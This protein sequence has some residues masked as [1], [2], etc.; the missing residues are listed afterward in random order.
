MECPF[1]KEDIKDGAIKCKHCGSMLEEIDT[2]SVVK[3]TQNNIFC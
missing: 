1:C 3:N 2:E